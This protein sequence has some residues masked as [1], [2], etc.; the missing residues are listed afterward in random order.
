[1]KKSESTIKKKNKLPWKPVSIDATAFSAGAL[2][3]LVGIEELCDYELTK[4][5]GV[6]G[7]IIT[8]EAKKKEK[9]AKRKV[10]G[11]TTDPP[12]KKK[13][14]SEFVVT[15][16]D[17][18]DSL[19]HV[20][21][22]KAKKTKN[23]PKKRGY[24]KL[25]NPDPAAQELSS[26]KEELGDGEM[27]LHRIMSAWN[28]LFVPD[29]ILKALY[30]LG[31]KEPTQIQ[32]LS[33]PPAIKGRKDVMGAAETGSGKTLAFGIPI[34]AGIMTA[35]KYFK[36][37]TEESPVG[38]PE[39]EN[40]ETT[41]KED[42]SQS[43]EDVDN[44]DT[45]IES[46]EDDD[47]EL[48]SDEDEVVMDDDVSGSED[49]MLE[50]CG[51]EDSEIEDVDCDAEQ[52]LIDDE[53]DMESNLEE[54]NSEDDSEDFDIAEEENSLKNK[55]NS[56]NKLGCV[57]VVYN[58]ELPG[59]TKKMPVI[60][61]ENRFWALI[62]APT[63]EL[64]IQ[65]YKH[66]LAAAKYTGIKMAVLVGGMA[67]QKQERILRRCPE[68]VVATPGRLWELIK[69]G[70]A[71]LSTVDQIRFLA[72]DETDRMLEAGHFQ[73]LK[74]LLVRINQGNARHRR[75]NFMFSATL[76]L[77][78]DV[79]RRK[80]FK[81]KQT[82]GQK[83]HSLGQLIGL[84]D[85]KIVDVTPEGAT[86]TGLIETRLMT[87]S[88]L[89]RDIRLVSVLETLAH[90]PLSN[91]G[92]LTKTIVF[93]NSVGGVR[94][95]NG[96]LSA[97]KLCPV[98][99]HS[100]MI[101]KQRLRSLEKFSKGGILLATD[102]AARGLDL[103]QVDHVIHFQVPHTSE[104]YVHRSGRTAR[105]KREGLS[106]LLVEPKEVQFYNRLCKTLGKDSGLPL[107]PLDEHLV[108]RVKERVQV[109]KEID[110][111]EHQSRRSGAEEG[112][113]HKTAEEA[114][115]L[116]DDDYVSTKHII[117]N[118]RMKKDLVFKKKELDALL[119]KTLFPAGFSPRYPT[120]KGGLEE[121]TLGTA[122]NESVQRVK[123][124]L[125]QRKNKRKQKKTK[126]QITKEN[127]A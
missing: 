63:R 69:D 89:D 13:E 31:F 103:P 7:R 113:L 71:H 126:K 67:Q 16:C 17:S 29:P 35:K 58:V 90:S 2:E 3:G 20:T 32:K 74:D 110:F 72:V 64:A 86:A 11:V 106:V 124:A 30:E 5:G 55:K 80:K 127:A 108:A 70:N 28:G 10:E 41:E 100:G 68:V 104:T 83:L 115:I 85:P 97:L 53:N 44:G 87:S 51:V 52:A 4:S 84:K 59:T 15:S 8:T 92:P 54:S 49:E 47:E 21:P 117:D 116:V 111:L 81:R 1:M 119:R 40:K 75:Q 14:R 43:E 33:L 76:S 27:N 88:L 121:L 57:K 12:P 23:R 114:D 101:Q 65:V 78:H 105:G 82:P 77:V 118:P 34:L 39:G 96:I 26:D 125:Q 24:N 109:A 42:V 9:N 73:E 123:A 94:R 45:G 102:V 60:K 46:E 19:K 22:K 93:C 48:A 37:N 61:P 95:L 18:V 112:W 25:D 38:D 50:D 122:K 91:S 107:F 66:L 120:M 98:T 99:L 6:Q 36:P 79:P 56:K 62:L